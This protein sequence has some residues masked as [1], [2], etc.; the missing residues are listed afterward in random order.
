[1]PQSVYKVIELVGT[2][3]ESWNDAAKAAILRAAETLRDLRIGGSDRPR[4]CHHRRQG[5]GLQGQAE[6]VIQI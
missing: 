2:S 5:R 6:S 4:R 3:T 1:M